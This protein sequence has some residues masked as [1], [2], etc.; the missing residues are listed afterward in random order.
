MVIVGH[1]RAHL[2]WKADWGKTVLLAKIDMILKPNHYVNL[3]LLKSVMHL[4]SSLKL[5]LVEKG[6]AGKKLTTSL[7]FLFSL[8]NVDEVQMKSETVFLIIKVIFF[9][10]I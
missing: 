4:L 6:I 2:K 9:K 1:I 8:E 5:I 7:M 3:S 10:I